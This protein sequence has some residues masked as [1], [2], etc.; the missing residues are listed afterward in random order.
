[1]EKLDNSNSLWPGRYN[2][3]VSIYYPLRRVIK[4]GVPDDNNTEELR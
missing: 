1:M 3:V 4:M 2:L